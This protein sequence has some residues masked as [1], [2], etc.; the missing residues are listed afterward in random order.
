M[1]VISEKREGLG[2]ATMVL[3]ICK[4]EAEVSENSTIPRGIS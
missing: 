4:A 1:P 3:I 2:D